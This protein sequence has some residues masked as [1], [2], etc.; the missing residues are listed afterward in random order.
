M[1]EGDS[2]PVSGHVATALRLAASSFMISCLSSMFTNTDPCSSTCENSGLPG[3]G[4]VA[5][6]VFDEVSNTETLLLRPLNAQTVFVDGSNM[7]ASGFV[8]AAT[9]AL[10]EKS[11][12]LK[13]TITLPAPSLM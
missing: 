6:T 11:A 5:T 7:I 12:R 4:I 8:P 9:V 2:Q 1:P 10:T 13:T 3:T